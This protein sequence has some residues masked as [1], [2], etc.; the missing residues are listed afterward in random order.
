MFLTNSFF[1]SDKNIAFQMEANKHYPCDICRKAFK[2]KA[3]LIRHT[4]IHT[5][6]KPYKCDICKKNFS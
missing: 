6:E 5:G 4:R 2:K 1:Y 3:D